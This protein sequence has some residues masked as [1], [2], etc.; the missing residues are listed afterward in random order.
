[1]IHGSY[2]TYTN[3]KCRCEP[4]RAA[5]R[6]YTSDLRQRL[7]ERLAADPS[8]APHGKSSTYTNW[9]CRCGP[10]GAAQAARRRRGAA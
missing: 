9:G 3:H 10:C 4:C 8:L 2:L 5:W 6:T 1:M 7:A